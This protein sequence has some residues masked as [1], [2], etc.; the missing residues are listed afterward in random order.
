[1]L[2]LGFTPDIFA[3]TALMSVVGQRDANEAYSIYVEMLSSAA[4]RPNVVTVVTIIRSTMKKVPKEVGIP[5][6]MSIL[7]DASTLAL[8]AIPRSNEGAAPVDASAEGAS[9]SLDASIFVAAL[10]AAVHYLDLKMLVDVLHLL[11][12]SL[13]FSGNLSGSLRKDVNGSESVVRYSELTYEIIGKFVA[14]TRS[15]TERR[16]E[17]EYQNILDH[18]S[19]LGL[20]D[21]VDIASIEAHIVMRKERL[22]AAQVCTDAILIDSYKLPG[23]SGHDASVNYAKG[24]DGGDCRSKISART[25]KCPFVDPMGCLGQSTPLPLR[26]SVI[27]HDLNRLASRLVTRNEAL[28][29]EDFATLIHQCRKRKWP[30]QVPAILEFIDALSTVGIP[31]LN[32]SPQPNLH[33]TATTYDAAFESYFAVS[34]V[35]DAWEL[36]IRIFG[37]NGGTPRVDNY[38][39]LKCFTERMQELVL[40]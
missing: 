39:L 12:K 1:M 6:I 7:H 31:D 33:A 2:E 17:K 9:L 19:S 18:L 14:A 15:E 32:L 13:D 25:A 28:S 16:D 36:F 8:A 30:E 20:V 22:Q 21:D 34:R 11:R 3:Y 5:R 10:S 26:A 29:E 4:T 27:A 37:V 38:V 35:D 24:L 40:R 23:G